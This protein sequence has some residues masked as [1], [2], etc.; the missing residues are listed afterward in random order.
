MYS[1][2]L[3][4]TQPQL[5]K[6]AVRTESGGN[7]QWKGGNGVIRRFKFREPVTITFLTQ[8]RKQS[9][10]GLAGGEPGKTGEQFLISEDGIKSQLDGVGTYQISEGDR[11]EIQTPGGGGYGFS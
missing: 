9:P 8:H 11:I 4:S 5:E 10:Y 6:F 2:Y 3:Y 1:A 7:G